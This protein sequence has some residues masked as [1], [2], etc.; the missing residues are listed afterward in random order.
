[1]HTFLGTLLAD[2]RRRRRQPRATAQR[3]Q[4]PGARPEPRAAHLDPQ[5]E[6]GFLLI[7]VIVSALL[8]ALIVVA[9]FNGFDVATRLSSDQR[10]HDQAALLAAQSQEQLR[11][12]PATTLDALESVP[13]TF[14]S[15]V[16]GTTY[17]ITQ[18]A[19][20]VSASGQTTGCNASE[21]NGQAG[22]NIQISSSVTWP[23]L[24][25]AKRPAV[26]QVS[27]ITPPTGST[28][29][30]D[31]TNGAAT[32]LPVSGV[33][34]TA[35]YIP[36]ESAAYTTAEGTTG[37][38]GCVVLTGLAT[39]NATIEIAEK[40]NFV[41]TSGA[42]KVPN[43]ELAI[44]PNITT[45]YPV[46][47]AEGGK[48]TAEYTYK[49]ATTWEGKPVKSDTFVAFNTA[50]PAGFAE[51]EVGSTG[52]EYE[53]GGE[54]KY[55]AQTSKYA[56]TATTAS[57]TKYLNGD[58]FPF[59]SAWAVYGGDCT[60]NNTATVTEATEKL[61]D[62][63]A[64]VEAGKTKIV[65]VP[66]SY[67]QLNVKSGTLA[68]PGAL[69][70]TTYPAKITNAECKSAE[71]PDNATSANL[72]HTQST[73]EGHL[74]NPFQPFGSF[75]LC[76]YNATTKRTDTATYTNNTVAGSAITFY[77]AEQSKA[78]RE[79]EEATARKKREAEELAAR[80]TWKTEEAKGKITST[81]R[82]E[83]ETKQSTERAAAEAA[84]KTKK[85][86]AET[87]EAKR[88]YTVASGQSG[89]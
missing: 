78:E 89:C 74:E 60:K 52:F 25:P 84:E 72:T 62:T 58:L 7:E 3:P 75:E 54:E 70:S 39:T 44:A 47:Y 56:A 32:P 67:V 20:P 21:T 26:K 45:H 36:V 16:G 1:M 55:K 18:E 48:I 40:P 87:E 23:Q 35:R 82:K 50:I 64:V 79:A 8:V 88:G 68:K 34:A 9:T 2:H 28:L 76:I 12:D 85:T 80:E 57:A 33:T 59:P 73:S 83:K 13:H 38:A 51:Y 37:V 15:T 77:P 69:E 63:T 65:K 53:V 61:S 4:S 66:L 29:E 24:T 46:T 42:P 17:T 86:E 11:S 22:A 31:V 71:V 41:D 10:H 49:G 27:V 19:K 6:D 43:Q 5:A 30:V 81:Q 14:T